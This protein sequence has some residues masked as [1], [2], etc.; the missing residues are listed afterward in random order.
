MMPAIESKPSDAVLSVR[1]ITELTSDLHFLIAQR[2]CIVFCVFYRVFCQL[3]NSVIKM[4]VR[5][6]YKRMN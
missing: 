5:E 6:P 2:L 3:T 1:I 4:G